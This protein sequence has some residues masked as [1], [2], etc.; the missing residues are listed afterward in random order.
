LIQ[1]Q[2]K[3]NFESATNCKQSLPPK[4]IADCDSQK[5]YG[6]NEFFSDLYQSAQKLEN[7]N[8]F[9]EVLQEM[10]KQQIL[11]LTEQIKHQNC[12]Q[13]HLESSKNETASFSQNLNF[14]IFPPRPL[15][16]EPQPQI[17]IFPP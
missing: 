13:S 14:N 10:V 15:P 6:I 4:S 5:K 11:T 16:Q 2:R 7:N 8:C 9:Q 17:V 1:K 3:E 12:A